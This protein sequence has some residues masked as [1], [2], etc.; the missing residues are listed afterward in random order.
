VKGRWRLSSE[1]VLKMSDSFRVKRM[2]APAIPTQM[3]ELTAFWHG[4]A[5]QSI[6]STMCKL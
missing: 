5:E 4:T 1:H 2:T 3:I 6:G